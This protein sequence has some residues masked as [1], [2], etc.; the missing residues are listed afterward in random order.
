MMANIVAV[1]RLAT[2]LF[3]VVIATVNNCMSGWVSN[4]DVLRSFDNCQHGRPSE[5]HNNGLAASQNNKWV[6]KEEGGS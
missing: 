2:V 6:K 3:F 5:N 1:T 4:C